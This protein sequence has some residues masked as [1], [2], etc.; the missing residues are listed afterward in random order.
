MV[1]SPSPIRFSPS[2]A[3]C[4]LKDNEKLAYWC[5]VFCGI[6][7]VWRRARGRLPGPPWLVNHV[8]GRPR[9]GLSTRTSTFGAYAEFD[10]IRIWPSTLEEPPK[11]LIFSCMPVARRW[12]P[13][14]SSFKF[15]FYA[16]SLSRCFDARFLPR[17][18]CILVHHRG[19]TA[20]RTAAA[21]RCTGLLTSGAADVSR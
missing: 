17:F 4:F 3:H 10:L 11:K 6:P 13:Q 9:E 19:E 18:A 16:G 2:V 14:T 8:K 1:R 7:R 21:V 15:S 5:V 12:T 20:P